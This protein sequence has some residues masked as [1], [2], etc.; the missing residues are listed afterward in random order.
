MTDI[1]HIDVLDSY[2]NTA[3]RINLT[4][5]RTVKVIGHKGYIKI[6]YKNGCQKW[7]DMESTILIM[8]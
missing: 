4:D 8:N 5:V 1:G 7:F 2:G 3:E 6:V